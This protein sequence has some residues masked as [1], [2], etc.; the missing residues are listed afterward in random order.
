MAESFLQN[1]QLTGLDRQARRTEI[2]RAKQFAALD[3]RVTALE[4]EVT[5]WESFTPVWS[6]YTRGNGTTVAYKRR[7]G[8]NLELVIEETLGSTS[9][10]GTAILTLP[11]SLSFA[12][13]YGTSLH[14][15]GFVSL[16]EAGVGTTMGTARVD[17]GGGL[18]VRF[19][20]V[21]AS[22]VQN[23]GIS[24]TAPFTWGTGDILR[25]HVSMP[26]Q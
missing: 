7:V 23:A 5:D 9:S 19:L 21:A 16:V 3:S 6:G 1:A 11:D 4:A 25:L 8:Q 26:V 24:S 17:S 18:A 15:M 20:N 13:W 2:L 12:S 14:P 22:E 10:M